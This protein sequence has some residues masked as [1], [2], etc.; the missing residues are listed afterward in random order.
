MELV[1]YINSDN[2]IANVIRRPCMSTGV[3]AIKFYDC[4]YNVLA[5]C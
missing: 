4:D 5:T 3:D 1:T 2:Y